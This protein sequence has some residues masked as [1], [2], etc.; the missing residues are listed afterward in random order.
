MK[1]NKQTLRKDEAFVK[2]CKDIGFLIDG[3][4]YEVVCEDMA[5]KREK[6]K[7]CGWTRSWW[8]AG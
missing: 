6:C 2:P 7:K 4:D 3:H 8:N 5:N 1:K